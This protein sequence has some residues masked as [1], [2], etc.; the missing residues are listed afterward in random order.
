MMDRIIGCKRVAL[1]ADCGF[2]D[3]KSASPS[4]CFL[5]QQFAIS[6]CPTIID[7]ADES[8]ECT[9]CVTAVKRIIIL[10][11]VKSVC[12]PPDDDGQ[13]LFHLRSVSRGPSI[14]PMPAMSWNPRGPS[15]NIFRIYIAGDIDA[16]PPS[17]TFLSRFRSHD[18]HIMIF[19]NLRSALDWEHIFHQLLRLLLRL[20]G[21]CKFRRSDDLHSKMAKSWEYNFADDEW[22]TR[23]SMHFHSFVSVSSSVHSWSQLKCRSFSVLLIPCDDLLGYILVQLTPSSHR[24]TLFIDL[25]P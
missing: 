6:V 25:Q 13:P 2:G 22:T 19:V 4:K 21:Q 9:V 16:T 23:Y 5:A 1:F 15:L 20:L 24:E 10:F 12:A 17:P 18:R 14:C 3:L 8:I 11:I 7:P